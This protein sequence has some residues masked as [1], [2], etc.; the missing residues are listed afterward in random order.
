MKRFVLIVIF[1]TIFFFAF[2]WNSELYEQIIRDL[3][4]EKFYG[5]GVVNQGDIKAAKYV[6]GIFSEIGLQSFEEDYFQHFSISVNSFPGDA[7]LF[8]DG[9]KLQTGIDFV[10]TEFSKGVY[11]EF[12]LYYFDVSENSLAD[13]LESAKN[14]DINGSFLVIDFDFFNRYRVYLSALSDPLIPGFVF[15]RDAPIRW[16]VSRSYFVGEQVGIWANRSI[17]PTDAG[18]IEINLENEFL[19]NYPTKNVI[20]YVEGKE[21]PKEYYVFTAHFDHLGQHGR[22]VF[23]PG[24]NDNASGVAM[25]AILAEYFSMPENQPDKSVVFMGFAAEESGLLG[26]KFYVENPLFPLSDI[27]YLINLDMI[28]DNTEHLYME[29]SGTGE[30]GLSLIYS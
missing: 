1:L 11:G 6:S 13:L 12:E 27:K 23:Y 17:F 2:P 20:G 28:A 19:E 26:S 5:R 10:F 24:A 3:S 14:G 25:L 18:K 8:V 30:K 29:V 22:E 4:S 15:L 16:W 9:N 21:Y 7:H